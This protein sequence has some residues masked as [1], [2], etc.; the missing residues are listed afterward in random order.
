M[1]TKKWLWITLV[2]IL[3]LVILAGVGAAGYRLGLTQNPA[4]IQQLAD[5]RAQRLSQLPNQGANQMP[6][7]NGNGISPQE[8]GFNPHS[9]F[10]RGNDRGRGFDRRDGFAS[11]LFG[12]IHLIILGALVWFGYKY[13]KNS[14]WKL[15]REVP[16]ASVVENDTASVEEE[17]K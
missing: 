17:K 4:V 9:N 8:Q 2:S 6:K 3:T 5:L 16:P 1:K 13:I 10:D 15:V 7:G 14:G 12:L 11:P